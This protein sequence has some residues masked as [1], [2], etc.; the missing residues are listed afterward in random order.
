MISVGATIGYDSLGEYSNYG[1]S[2]DVAAPGTAVLS[3]APG[4]TDDFEI[5]M[6][7]TSMAA[8]FVAGMASGILTR[9]K[10]LQSQQVKRIILETVDKKEWLEGKVATSGVVNIDRAFYTAELT[11]SMGLDEAI[12]LSKADVADMT[13]DSSSC[14]TD[15][16]SPCLPRAKSVSAETKKVINQIFNLN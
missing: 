10:N 13:S 11:K 15:F 8:P 12:S 3:S 9:N 14:E 5:E 7:G 1:M 2:V 16:S 6:T 4:L